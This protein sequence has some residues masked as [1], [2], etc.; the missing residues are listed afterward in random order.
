MKKTILYLCAFSIAGFI[1]AQDLA[2]VTSHADEPVS[3][4]SV[5][6][7]NYVENS[8]LYIKR[9]KEIQFKVASFNVKNLSIYTPNEP[10]TYQVSF[11]TEENNVTASYNHNGELLKSKEKYINIRLPLEVSSKLSKAYPN[12]FFSETVCTVQYDKNSGTVVKYKIILE[13][14]GKKKT[15]SLTI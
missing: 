15:V 1:S 10:A 11:N 5:S 14:K 2:M 12:W 9:V 7:K 6:N 3:L 4:S 13:K 8:I